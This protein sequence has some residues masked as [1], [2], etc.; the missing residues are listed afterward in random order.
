MKIEEEKKAK[1]LRMQGKSFNEISYILKVSK[2][3]IN[4]WV[5][6]IIL[7]KKQQEILNMKNPI[8]NK[9]V[10]GANATKLKYF[11]LRKQYQNDGKKIALQYEPLHIMG[12]M[13]YWAE[14]W[15]RNNNTV[16]AFCNSDINIIKLFITFLKKYYIKDNKNIKIGINCFPDIKSVLAIETYWLKKLNLPKTCLRKTMVN[17]YSK[18][19]QKKRKNKLKYGVCSI[20]VCNVKILQN[21]YGAIQQ[22]I[23]KYIEVDAI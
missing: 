5:K 21:I 6:D 3:S 23:K 13:L 8:Y 7:T 10:N 9:N 11:K 22:Y 20:Y 16:V 12:C 17:K 15:K 2:R 19:S 18:S 1:K 4:R 14:G